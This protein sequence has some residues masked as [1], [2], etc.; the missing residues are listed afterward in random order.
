MKGVDYGTSIRAAKKWIKENN[1]EKKYGDPDYINSTCAGVIIALI[2]IYGKQLYA[3][4]KTLSPR[5]KPTELDRSDYSNIIPCSTNNE[6]IGKEV[7]CSGRTVR[8]HLVK[9]ASMG[10][11]IEKGYHGPTQNFELW[12]NQEIIQVV[13]HIFSID[14]EKDYRK[15]KVIE[16]Q[17]TIELQPETEDVI[18]YLEKVVK[19]TLNKRKNGLSPN[20]FADKM[21][22]IK[23]NISFRNNKKNINAEKLSESHPTDAEKPLTD[24]FERFDASRR[25][26]SFNGTNKSEGGDFG[27]NDEKYSAGGGGLGSRLARKMGIERPNSNKSEDKLASPT[28]K[29]ALQTPPFRDGQ[30]F[31]LAQKL[32]NSLWKVSA[33]LLYNE[34]PLND[35]EILRARKILLLYYATAQN[36]EE[37]QSFHLNYMERI[38]MVRRWMNRKRSRYVPIPSVYFDPRHKGGF[39]DTSEWL[40]KR[41]A[42]KTFKAKERI[43]KKCTMHYNLNPTPENYQLQLQKVQTLQEPKLEGRFKWYIQN[44]ITNEQLNY[45]IK[46]PIA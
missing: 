28:M 37:M 44:N 3:H 39:S 10:F 36:S 17:K 14:L 22:A 42:D 25:E 33:A 20:S 29:D 1:K 15:A 46:G 41:L 9:L 5:S 19:T 21:S 12:I 38:A 31:T 4:N 26:T 34:T 45:S 23:E 6:E 18:Q 35:S 27:A 30:L 8:R 40:K 7:G 24:N 2:R 16:Q 32:S 43:T 13:P 11:I